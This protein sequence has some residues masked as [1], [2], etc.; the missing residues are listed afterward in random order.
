MAWTSESVLHC[1]RGP[2]RP[3]LPGSFY[4]MSMEILIIPILY[5]IYHF[6]V[7]AFETSALNQS[8]SQVSR[9]SSDL[10]WDLSCHGEMPDAAL[11]SRPLGPNC[12]HSVVMSLMLAAQERRRTE[13]T[14]VGSVRFISLYSTV[15]N[16]RTT[17][18]TPILIFR[19]AVW[20]WP[21]MHALCDRWDEGRRTLQLNLY[22]HL[23]RNE[24]V[25]P[26]AAK[27]TQAERSSENMYS[28]FKE[29]T[30][31][32]FGGKL[33]FAMHL[34]CI[35]FNF[36]AET[37]VSSLLEDPNC[38]GQQPQRSYAAGMFST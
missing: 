3:G 25:V 6:M 16:F 18:K 2:H 28:G 27:T 22:M 15:Q 5:H 21:C 4:R 7:T 14:A 8:G 20:G 12:V 11:P 29:C 34:L 24:Q 1:Y 23:R 9:S 10:L 26:V 13:R 30:C 32:C 36:T 37:G 31:V 33:R 19:D 38:Y 35:K 17:L